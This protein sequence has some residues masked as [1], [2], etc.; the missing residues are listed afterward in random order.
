M[1]ACCLRGRART[2]KRRSAAPP[3]RRTAVPPLRH[4][5]GYRNAGLAEISLRFSE[6]LCSNYD[7][8]QVALYRA[9]RTRPSP[10]VRRGARACVCPRCPRR[11]RGADRRRGRRGR[12][13]RLPVVQTSWSCC[14][15][16]CPPPTMRPGR[17]P[18]STTTTPARV[19]HRRQRASAAGARLNDRPTIGG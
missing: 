19:L 9:S 3:W 5:Y 6:L 15:L 4:K 1:S 14:C 18:P 13:G 8:E 17:A 11:P 12:A 16:C 10:Q 7:A 2:A